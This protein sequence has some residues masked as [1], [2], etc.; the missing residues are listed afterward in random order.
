MSRKFSLDAS[1]GLYVDNAIVLARMAL[2][3]VHHVADEDA[4][5]EQVEHRAPS[6]RLVT[7]RHAL[8]TYTR[9]RADTVA[10]SASLTCSTRLPFFGKSCPRGA[11]PPIHNPLALSAAILSRTLTGHSTLKLA[12]D[13]STFTAIYAAPPARLESESFCA[14]AATSSRIVDSDH[15]QQSRNSS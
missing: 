8:Q 1:E 14:G 9:F 12:K 7:C 10:A 15:E 11:R 13:S 5:L 3:V 2:S 6:E 4:I